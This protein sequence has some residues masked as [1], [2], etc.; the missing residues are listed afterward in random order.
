[1]LDFGISKVED[2]AV[3]SSESLLG[4]PLYMSP[5]QVNDSAQVDARTDVRPIT[6]STGFEEPTAPDR[7]DTSDRS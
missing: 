7:I 6:S 2:V 3:T 1:V 5:E 4:T